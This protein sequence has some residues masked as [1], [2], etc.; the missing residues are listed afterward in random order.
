MYSPD[1][2]KDEWFK[3]LGYMDVEDN[4]TRQMRRETSDEFVLRMSS[5]VLL[6]GAIVQ[7]DAPGNPAGLA[8]GWAW[9]A[10]CLNSLPPTR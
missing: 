2:A 6:Y 8:H 4:K 9:L 3:T 7:T 1:Q 10:R 5:M